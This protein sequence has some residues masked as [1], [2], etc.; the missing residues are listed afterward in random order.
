MTG[1][2]RKDEELVQPITLPNGAATTNSLGIDLG[3][4]SRG[5]FVA[6]CE[7]VVNAP[8]LTTGELGD[9]QTITYSVRH[10]DNADFSTDEALFNSVIVQTGA[11]GVGDGAEEKRLRLPTNVKRYIRL[12]A[13]KTGATN[14]STAAGEMSL[15]T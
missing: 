5:D 8:E 3:N 9:T 11:G 2:L 4:S 6:D 14:A 10:D 13:V 15:R 12:R 7:L 1:Y